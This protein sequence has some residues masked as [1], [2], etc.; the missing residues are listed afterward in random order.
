M[1]APAPAPISSAAAIAR[2]ILVR[3]RRSV[4]PRRTRRPIAEAGTIPA[5]AIPAGAIPAGAIPAGA[6]PSGSTARLGP[7]STTGSAESR[8]ARTTG[9]RGRY[10]APAG[11]TGLTFDLLAGFSASTRT[12]TCDTTAIRYR[13][14]CQPRLGQACT[15]A[16]RLLAAPSHG[17]SST[18][19][20]GVHQKI[21]SCVVTI[22]RVLGPCGGMG[23]SD[24][25]RRTSGAATRRGQAAG[26]KFGRRQV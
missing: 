8:W 15:A 6:T 11:W 24:A 12:A 5:G 26:P 20:T 7:G 3:G 14:L 22:R 1:P 16:G 18:S 9:R 19:D 17:S 4:V 25:G 13:R 23:Y 10:R 2:P 21:W